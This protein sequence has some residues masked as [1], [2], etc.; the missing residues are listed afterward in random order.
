MKK[1]KHYENELKKISRGYTKK[2]IKENDSFIRASNFILM[3]DISMSTLRK[4]INEGIINGGV[5]FGVLQVQI[6]DLDSILLSDHEKNL[7]FKED[8]ILG[9]SQAS[10]CL[11][12]VPVRVI[13]LIH[14]GRLPERK[15]GNKYFFYESDLKNYLMKKY[16]TKP[17]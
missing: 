13:Q 10:T 16:K 1:I 7:D 4:W 17:Y 9:L 15:I 12:L 6:R 2:E 14:L 8:F 11:D 5:V 3:I